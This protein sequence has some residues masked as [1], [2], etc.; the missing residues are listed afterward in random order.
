M[1][2]QRAGVCLGLEWI[3]PRED[4]QGLCLMVGKGE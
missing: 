4:R 3:L 1:W 2:A